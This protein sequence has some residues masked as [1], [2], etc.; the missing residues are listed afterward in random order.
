[1]PDVARDAGEK[2]RG[3]TAFETADHR[4]LGDG[5]AFPGIVAEEERVNPGR[6]AAHDHI[7]VVAGENL[8]LD[9]IT[10]AEE[11]GDGPRFAPGTEGALREAFRTFEIPSRKFRAGQGRRLGL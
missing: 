9:K 3:V 5:M 7:L 4:H 1:M 8:R 11:I 10:R 2:D 6:V